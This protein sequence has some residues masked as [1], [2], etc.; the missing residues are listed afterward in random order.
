M[1]AGGKAEDVQGG[2]IRWE[3][4][5]LEFRRPD[6]SSGSTSLT[7]DPEKSLWASHLLIRKITG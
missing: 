4:T 1:G 3:T 2:K 5:D 6:S 7:W